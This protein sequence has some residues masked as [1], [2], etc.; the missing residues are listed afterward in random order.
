MGTVRIE[1]EAAIRNLMGRAYLRD[2]DKD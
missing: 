2:L 1:Y